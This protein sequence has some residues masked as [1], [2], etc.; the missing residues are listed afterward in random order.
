MA[1]FHARPDSNAYLVPALFFLVGL[2]QVAPPF[3]GQSP[4]D[5]GPPV[6]LVWDADT[7]GRFS[8]GLACIAAVYWVWP[9][10]YR[11]EVSE[12]GIRRVYGAGFWGD[13]TAR[14]F[15]IT[16]AELQEWSFRHESVQ[17]GEEW[18]PHDF[19]YVVDGSGRAYCLGGFAAQIRDELKRWV[20]EKER[21]AEP[22]VAT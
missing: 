11:V 1:T 6:D 5:G 15:S 19:V 22:V 12:R 4:S 18:F 13:H 3:W 21:S 20:P 17:N 2:S 9:R 8:L 10:P 14:R 7:V 16:W